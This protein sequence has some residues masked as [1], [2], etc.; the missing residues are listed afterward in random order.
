MMSYL[1]DGVAGILAVIILF[2]NGIS[3]FFERYFSKKLNLQPEKLVIVVTGCD[4]GFGQMVSTK[5]ASLGFHVIS[6]C[7][8]QEGVDRMEGIVSFVV[9]S[10]YIQ[11]MRE[12]I[13]LTN[14][15][16]VIYHNCAGL[17]ILRLSSL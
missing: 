9:C 13:L 14:H 1:I 10:V 5:L 2:L 16:T 15:F 3:Y 12:F 17:F 11:D 4:T 8:T 6:G 7:L